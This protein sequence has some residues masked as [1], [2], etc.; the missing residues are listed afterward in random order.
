MN[1]FKKLFL[2]KQKRAVVFIFTVYFFLFAFLPLSHA[3][4]VE[5]NHFFSL[6]HTSASDL[7][8]H[9]EKGNH[10]HDEHDS[11]HGSC[12]NNSTDNE[13]HH[14]FL[15]ELFHYSSERK[16]LLLSVFVST[17]YLTTLFNS[18]VL[19]NLFEFSR[20]CWHLQPICWHKSHYSRLVSGNSPPFSC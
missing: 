18:A 10:H 7:H 12:C 6:S 9:N 1:S 17:D 13:D 5:E 15:N 2:K 14:H 8:Q 3:H 20:V 19:I 11:S 16:R 4:E